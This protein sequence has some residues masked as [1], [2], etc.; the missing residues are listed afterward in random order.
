MRTIQIT[1]AAALFFSCLTPHV[2][3]APDTEGQWSAQLDWP[4]I[5]IHTVLTPQGNVFS[6]GTDSAGIQGAQFNYDLWSPDAGTGAASHNTLTNTLGVDSFCSAALLL[7]ESGDIL[8]SG[9][10]AR[11]QGFVNRGINSAPIFNTTNNTL[12]SAADMNSARWY[13]TSTTLP[14]GE[15]LLSGGRDGE[16][17]SVVTPEI[18]TPS[19][20]TWRSLLGIQTTAY[21]YWYPRQWV[22]PDGRVFGM[23]AKKMYYMDTNGIGSLQV[24]PNLPNVSFGNTSTAV[25]Y[26][27][28]KILQVSGNGTGSIVNGAIVVDVTGTTPVVRETNRPTQAGRRWANGVVLPDGKVMVVG[29]ST[30][31]NQLQ[32]VSYNPEIWDPATE[33][34]S[35]MAAAQRSRLYHSTALLMKDGRVLV[36]GGGAPGPEVNTNAEIFSP[37]YLFDSNGEADRPTINSAPAEAPYGANIMVSHPDANNIT[38]VTLVKTGAVTH[39]FNMEQRF[40][41]LDFSDT[42]GGVR[43]DI[44][45]SANIATPG[46]YL[47]FLIDNQGVPS[48]GHVIRLSDTA[49]Y[50]EPAYPVAITDNISATAGTPRNINVLANDTGES[51]TV[52]SFNQYSANAGTITRSGNQLRY[53]ASSSF[54]G[55][56][57]FWYVIK[58]SLGRTNSAK[59]SINVTGGASNPVPVGVADSLTAITGTAV[60]IDVLANDTGNGLNLNTPNTWSLRAGTVA[61]ANNKI[62]YTS[63]A[64]FTGEDKIWY[65]F[66]DVEGRSSWGEV[67]INVTA[68]GNNPNPV[69]VADNTVAVSGN[70]ITIDVLANDVGN[71]LVLNTPNPYSLRAGSVALQSNRLVYQSA[72]GFTEEDNIWYTFSDVEGRSHWA[73]VTINVSE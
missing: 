60:V 66:S 17:R 47:L 70:S 18:Y 37:P 42:S 19:T 55:T 71:G 72:A 40:I 22:V 13:P 32:G 26:E 25:M 68:S 5:G 3:A 69:G 57:T 15:I 54:N 28:G 46:H 38:R 73:K 59:V 61:L 56:D 14:N 41:E 2:F 34:W 8:M 11:P 44:P 36:A 64:G 30:V 31:A 50:N 48:E 6:W 53:T 33:Q 39:S 51:L 7:P 10:D 23:V 35:L 21:S 52:S 16:N 1:G 67:T 45:S 63:A 24:L 20:N 12:S 4:L 62:T 27:P 29:G 9:G 49:S 65:T 58:D 43:V